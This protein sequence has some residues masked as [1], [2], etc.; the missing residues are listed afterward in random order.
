[1]ITPDDI[2]ALIGLLQRLPMSGAEA[3]YAAGLCER[4]AAIF[5]PEPPAE[6]ETPSATETPDETGDPP[7]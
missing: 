2:Q 1:M 3:L 5:A 6:P 4:L 7:A